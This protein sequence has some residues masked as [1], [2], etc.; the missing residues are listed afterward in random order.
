MIF[1]QETFAG[2]GTRLNTK[3]TNNLALATFYV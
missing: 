3:A 1:R 2:T